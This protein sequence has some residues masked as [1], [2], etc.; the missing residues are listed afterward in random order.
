[1][2]AQAMSD[3]SDEKIPTGRGFIDLLKRIEDDCEDWT[4][5]RIT[6]LGAKAPVCFDQLGTL[7][8]LL[9]RASSCF[10]GCRGG[11]HI[12]EYFAGRIASSSLR[13][14]SADGFCFLRRGPF[15]G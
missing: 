14:N 2:R 9:D 6:T 1:M 11:D 7:L 8:S 15:P 4:R 5:E 3:E 10:W 12:I 13:R